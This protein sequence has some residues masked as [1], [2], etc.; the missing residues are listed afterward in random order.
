[1]LEFMVNAM[2]LILRL[3]I[4]HSKMKIFLVLHLTGIIYL[5]SF[6]LLVCLVTKLTLTFDFNSETSQTMLSVSHIP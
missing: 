1:M 6:G 2:I 5:S 3:Y 4:F